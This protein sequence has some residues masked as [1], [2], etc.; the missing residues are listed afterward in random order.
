M[1]WLWFSA[2]SSWFHPSPA[3]QSQSFPV[4]T[5][6]VRLVYCLRKPRGL[7]HANLRIYLRRL[8]RTLRKNSHQQ[9]ARNCLSQ[10]RQQEGGDSTIGV[11]RRDRRHAWPFRRIFGRWRLLRRWLLLPLS[12]SLVPGD[13]PY[14]LA[15]EVLE[16]PVRPSAVLAGRFS[17]DNP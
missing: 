5:G 17:P 14:D 11:C 9:A 10:V 16:C 4:G 12:R 8:Q 7:H 2:R 15:P 1:T 13:L 6:P 3:G